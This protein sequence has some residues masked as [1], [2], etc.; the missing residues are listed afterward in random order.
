MIPVAVDARR[1]QDPLLTG[2]GRYLASLLPL[3]AGTVEV[4]LL[5]DRRRNL[6]DAFGYPVAALPGLGPL[7]ET[8][9]LQSSVPA[10]MAG[11]RQMLFHGTFNAIPVALTTRSVVTIHDLA[12]IHHPEDLGAAKRVAFS[13]QARW[14]ARH[15]DVVVT[16][17]D[18]MSKAIAEAYGVG[19]DRLAVVPLSVSGAFGPERAGDAAALLARLGVGGRYVVA[20]GGARRRGLAVAVAAW[21]TVRRERSDVG[22][23]L[24]VVGPERAPEEPGLV[25]TGPVDDRTWAGLLAGADALCYPTRYEGFGLPALEACASGTAVVCAPVAALGEVLGDA[26]EWA[27]APTVEAIAGALERVLVD[28]ARRQELEAAGLRRVA[29]GPDWADIAALTADAYRRARG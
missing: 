7:P 26:A 17:S 24:V 9:W 5:A 28:T 12:W 1:L 27:E 16:T 6:P 8:A 18:F 11:H 10:W 23:H 20:V 15:A 19:P 2:V 21:R 3:L 29:A 22:C 4:T 25:N 13:A 14:A